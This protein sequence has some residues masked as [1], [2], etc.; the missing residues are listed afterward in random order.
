VLIV[1]SIELVFGP[2]VKEK[3][4]GLHKIPGLPLRFIAELLM[5]IMQM[6]FWT[7]HDGIK[8]EM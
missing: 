1:F 7:H 4:V 6:L 5:Q 2:L 3:T 8:I